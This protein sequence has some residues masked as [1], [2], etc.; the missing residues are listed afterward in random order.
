MRHSASRR[1][2]GR[3]RASAGTRRPLLLVPALLLSLA[4]SLP[5]GA[6]AYWST[7]GSGV[8]SGTSGDLSAPVASATRTPATNTIV[9][10]WRLQSDGGE[11]MLF[12]VQR[13]PADEQTWIDVCGSDSAPVSGTSCSNTVTSTGSWKYRVI[14][15]KGSWRAIS[16]ETAAL[17]TVAARPTVT[18]NQADGQPDPTRTQ[19]IT[20]TAV[21]ERRVTGLTSDGIRIDRE[22]SVIGDAVLAVRGSGSTYSITVE[23]LGTTAPNGGTLNLRIVE[24]ATVDDYGNRNAASTSTDNMVRLDTTPPAAPTSVP[25]LTT[26]SGIAAR[27]ETLVDNRT[28]VLKMGFE[29]RSMVPSDANGGSVRLFRSTTTTGAGE[30]VGTGDIV[31]GSYSVDESPDAPPTSDGV[32]FYFVQ[33]V[34]ALGNPGDL[35]A[36]GDPSRRLAVTVDRSAP[37]LSMVYTRQLA[38]VVPLRLGTVTTSGIASTSATDVLQ[39]D[40]RI[41][42]GS[43][44][45]CSTPTRGTAA[46]DASTGAY[47]FTTDNLLGGILQTSVAQVTQTDIAGNVGSSAI[48]SLA[49]LLG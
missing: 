23:G 10:S 25:R 30:H 6:L 14:A 32:Y 33:Y 11:A 44:M 3:R 49:G 8:G 2:H 24:N 41:C 31:D 5:S 35:V 4:L 42:P 26:D 27:P 43:T 17:A 36:A 47:S 15:H 48:Q 12:H 22:G 38:S 13:S 28:N 34:D 46:V 1:R 21:F 29:Q 16:D 37:A 9:V 39:V 20:F 18:V 40:I 7:G 45:A 19:P